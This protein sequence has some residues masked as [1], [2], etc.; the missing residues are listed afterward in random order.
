MPQNFMMICNKLRSNALSDTE[1]CKQ[2][3]YQSKW[4]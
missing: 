2:A 4:A 3:A 1:V